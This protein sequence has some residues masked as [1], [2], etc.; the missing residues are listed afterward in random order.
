MDA[1]AIRLSALLPQ[2]L[3]KNIS[4]GMASK[5]DQEA[6]ADTAADT[7]ASYN[8]SDKDQLDLLSGKLSDMNLIAKLLGIGKKK[9]DSVSIREIRASYAEKF[10]QFTAKLDR[11]LQLGSI[12]RGSE[13]TLSIDAT[14]TVRVTNGHPDADKIEALFEND[15]ELANEFRGLSSMASFLRAADESQKFNAAYARDPD[16]AVMQF[17]H[18]FNSTDSKSFALRIDSDTI[19]GFFE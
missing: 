16:T 12:D 9:A 14:G 8:E 10:Q 17:S 3:S 19:S 2:S 7:A 13:A 1:S 15:P 11:L 6:A 4:S 5:G 18:L